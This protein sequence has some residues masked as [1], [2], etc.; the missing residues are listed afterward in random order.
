MSM[1]EFD[2]LDA[3]SKM[4]LN[5]VFKTYTGMEGGQLKRVIKAAE[6]SS[7]VTPTAWGNQQELGMNISMEEKKAPE[8]QKRQLQLSRQYVSS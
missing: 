2:K 6:D 3:E 1:E 5:I 4:R 8:E 7:K